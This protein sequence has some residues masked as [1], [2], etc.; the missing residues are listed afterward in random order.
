MNFEDPVSDPQFPPQNDPPALPQ[1]CSLNHSLDRQASFDQQAN[2]STRNFYMESLLDM[3]R[4]LYNG[5]KISVCGAYFAI[6]HFANKNKLTFTAIADLL[7]L[8]NLFCPKPN[9]IPAS[10]YIFKKFF[11]QFGGDFEKSTYC[12]ECDTIIEGK[13]CSTDNCTGSSGEGHFVHIHIN[14]FLQAV[15]SSE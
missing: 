2:S 15:V 7:E 5:S 1:N 12:M 11:K 14:K 6:M 10:C 13:S 4:P 9:Q 8:L 3:F